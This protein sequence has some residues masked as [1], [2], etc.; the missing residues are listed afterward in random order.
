MI[1][2]RFPQYRSDYVSNRLAQRLS[3]PPHDDIVDWDTKPS[4]G[5]QRLVE[6]SEVRTGSYSRNLRV[7]AASDIPAQTA[8]CSV[9]IRK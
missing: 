2:F 3:R 8:T 6:V 7:T 1:I 4:S 9:S 5:G